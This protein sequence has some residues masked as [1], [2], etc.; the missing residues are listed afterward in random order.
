MLSERLKNVAAEE[1][2]SP[3][4][5]TEL[6]AS[7]GP[8]V[9]RKASGLQPTISTLPPPPPSP[10]DHSWL[11]WK[12]LEN[13]YRQSKDT[14]GE[15]FSNPRQLVQTSSTSMPGFRCRR[16]GKLYRTK[17]TWKRHE[18]KEC[19]VTPQ[20][21][22]VHCDFVTKYKHNLKTHVRIKHGEPEG[23]HC[24][25]SSC[26]LVAPRNDLSN[27]TGSN[28]SSTSLLLGADYEG[29]NEPHNNELCDFSD[30]SNCD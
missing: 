19:G 9:H 25:G 14:K 17:Y 7:S 4:Y 23:S 11:V 2:A 8:S 12:Y 29:R 15:S 20:Y 28:N 26:G 16:C 24:D 30:D 18:R 6:L 10:A 22:C 21:H 13:K 5:S 1:N 3:T 27:L